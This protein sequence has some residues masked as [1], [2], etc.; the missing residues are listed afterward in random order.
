MTVDPLEE[1]AECTKVNKQRS[2][3]NNCQSNHNKGAKVAKIIR[4]AADILF[5]NKW[6]FP[7]FD[8]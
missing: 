5:V 7:G 8:P 2:P 4:G 1:F 6:V 3:N